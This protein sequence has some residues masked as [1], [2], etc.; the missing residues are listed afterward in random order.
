VLGARYDVDG[1]IETAANEKMRLKI[2]D[3]RPKRLFGEGDPLNAGV[4]V[5]FHEDVD[6]F[7]AA[8]RADL[9]VVPV[10][11]KGLFAPLAPLDTSGLH[12]RDFF[13]Q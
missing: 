8:L 10:V 6:G 1:S 11:R 9:E 4:L 7:L 3:L 12:L 13:E 2:G 5:R